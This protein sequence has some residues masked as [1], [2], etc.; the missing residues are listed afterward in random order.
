MCLFSSGTDYDLNVM[1]LSY[2]LTMNLMFVRPSW[3]S[4]KWKARNKKQ[5]VVTKHGSISSV[6][7]YNVIEKRVHFELSMYMSKTKDL[8][9]HKKNWF[10]KN[11]L[12]D[13]VPWCLPLFRPLISHG[14]HGLVELIQ[15]MSVAKRANG[16]SCARIRPLNA[17]R[18]RSCVRWQ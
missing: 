7:A 2:Y 14:C 16:N 12:F 9:D 10:L 4:I 11:H 17:Q 13:L 18:A 3:K 15:A 1:N 8:K 6:F 5:K